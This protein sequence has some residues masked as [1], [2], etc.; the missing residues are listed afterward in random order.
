MMCR[1]SWNREWWLVVLAPICN[2]AIAGNLNPPAGPVA[3][4]QRHLITTLPFVI[5]APGSYVVTGDLTGL[6]GQNGITINSHDVTIDLNGFTLRG[7]PG[8]LAGI[9]VVSA[10][11]WRNIV[12]LNGTVRNWGGDGINLVPSYNARLQGVN[13]ISNSNNGISGHLSFRAD[14]CGANENGV[15]G[16]GVFG[17][18]GSLSDCT[19]FSNG[20]HG[21]SGAQVVRFC[22]ASFNG[23]DGISAGSGGTVVGCASNSNSG[24]GFSLGGAT[25]ISDSAAQNNNSGGISAYLGDSIAQCTASYNN[26]PG[27]VGYGADVTISNTA[28]SNNNGS[29]ILIDSGDIAHC[30]AS[31]NQNSGIEILLGNAHIE[32]C[33]VSRNRADGILLADRST[34]ISNTCSENGALVGGYGAGIYCYGFESRIDGNHVSGNDVGIDAALPVRNTIMRNTATTNT[35]NYSIHPMNDFAPI[36]TAAFGSNPW[37]NIEY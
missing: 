2:T 27:I 37:A 8:S 21:M 13:A 18:N 20:G 23:G 22:T 10:P 6:A 1:K 7:V 3:P 25:R 11:P 17:A 28:A 19:A 4:T 15:W 34:A 29:G 31:N 35:F 32:G 5:S 12:I 16:I 26:G 14:K 36:S 30:T 33:T 24:Y 9:T